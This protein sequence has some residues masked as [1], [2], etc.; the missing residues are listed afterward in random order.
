MPQQPVHCMVS[1]MK[2]PL[3]YL[4][5]DV[6]VLHS[7]AL[8]A[9]ALVGWYHSHPSSQCDPSLTDITSQA[10]QQA[11]HQTAEGCEPYIAAIVGPFSRQT[12]KARSNVAWFSVERVGAGPVQAGNHNAVTGCVPMQLEV[13][14]C[15]LS[16]HCTLV[17]AAHLSGMHARTPFSSAARQLLSDGTLQVTASEDDH[18]DAGEPLYSTLSGLASQYTSQVDLNQD[19]LNQEANPAVGLFASR[20]LL[21]ISGMLYLQVSR[22]NLAAKRGSFKLDKLRDSVLSWLQHWSQD[23]QQQLWG[24]LEPALVA[25]QAPCNALSQVSSI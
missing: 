10:A 14:W 13:S 20:P 18:Q 7:P 3:P 4:V 5:A 24:R 17:A 25:F 11:A 9:L 15:P 16:Q 22:V 8:Q 12:S 6:S 21:S 1:L 19:L 2:D 23:A